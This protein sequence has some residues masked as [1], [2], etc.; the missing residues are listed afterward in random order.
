MR[1]LLRRIATRLVAVNMPPDAAWL[2]REEQ[3]Q[4][5]ELRAKLQRIS[6]EVVKIDRRQLPRASQ[7]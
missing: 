7:P 4:M 5:E 2:D 3:R 6:D 1:A